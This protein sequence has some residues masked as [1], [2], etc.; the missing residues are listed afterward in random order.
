M[1][2]AYIKSVRALPDYQL[3]VV[4]ETG[5]VVNLD[6]HTRLRSVRFGALEDEMLFRSVRTDGNYLLFSDGNRDRVQIG[7]KELMDI[8]LV[9]RTEGNAGDGMD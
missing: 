5:A 9:D 7:A 8:V 3:E 6:F 1:Q 2:R 4:M